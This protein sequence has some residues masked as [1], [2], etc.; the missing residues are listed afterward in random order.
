ML[1][2]DRVPASADVALRSLLSKLRAAV[3]DDLL[4]G[5]SDLSLALPPEAWVDYEAAHQAIHRAEA[6][7]A[8]EHWHD[9]WWPTRIARNIAHREFLS[10]VECRWVDERRAALEDLRLRAHEAIV[11]VGLGIGG[12]ELISAKRSARAIIDESPY[13]ES[14]YCLLMRAHAATGDVSE[15]LLVY[16]Q[17][18]RT[19]RD[20]LGTTPGPL[21]QALHSELIGVA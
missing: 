9:A 21:A 17:L 5:R 6:D 18:R 4:R 16:E 3:G 19:L 8:R 13:R 7:I 12:S 14:G 1:W 15:A 2:D 10:G 11:K 20:E